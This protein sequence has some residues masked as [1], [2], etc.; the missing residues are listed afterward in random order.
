M[1]N[2]LNITESQQIKT[3]AGVVKGVIAN[4]HTSGTL[5][6]FDGADS[7]AGTYATGTITTST[8]T[9]ATFP[10]STLTSDA[11]NNTEDETVTIGTTVYRWRDTLAQAYDVKLGASAAAS[12]DNLKAAI[13]ASG[14]PGT[15]YFAGTL[16]HPNVIAT[17]NTDTTQKVIST[18]IGTADNALAT[19]ETGAHTSW[20]DTTLGGGTGTSVTGVATADAT[21]V[22]DGVTYY[23]T[24][25]LSE[26][27]TDAV[28]NEIL[29]VTND[30]TALDNMRLAINGAGTEGTNYSTGTDA[31]PRVRATTNGATTQVIQSKIWGT[32]GN[33]IT[34]TETAAGASWGAATLTGGTEGARKL[35]NTFSFP[36]G[37]GVYE[38]PGEMNFEK[39]LYATVGNTADLTVIYQ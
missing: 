22:I 7:T 2:S 28:A 39:G 34:T 1:A 3:G 4:S 12:L 5:A 23:W 30:A 14:T 29:W 19:T 6:L 38:F 11:T 13:N 32:I 35:I 8:L 25:I 10:E 37:S 21:F 33:E 17:T 27:N 16:A 36:S 31:H 26:D 24:T 15:E 20:A 18:T 9:P